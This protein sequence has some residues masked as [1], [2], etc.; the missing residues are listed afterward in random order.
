MVVLVEALEAVGVVVA[1]EEVVGVF[2]AVRDWD[3]V[4]DA[5]T[6]GIQYVSVNAGAKPRITVF[7]P[8]VTTNIG[9]PPVT[10]LYR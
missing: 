1:E 6:V 2:D 5:V 3:A 10:V 8:A 7:A 4:D 9:E